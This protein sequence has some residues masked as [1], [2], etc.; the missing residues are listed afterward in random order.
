MTEDFS[1]ETMVVKRQENKTTSLKY[2]TKELSTQDSKSSKN[3][4]QE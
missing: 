3:I 4:F 2:A 1:S